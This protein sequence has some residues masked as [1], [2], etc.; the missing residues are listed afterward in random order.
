MGNRIERHRSEFR[1]TLIL[2]GA[3]LVGT[4][5]WA[6]AA[7]HNWYFTFPGAGHHWVSV[8]GPYNEHL[9]RD[10]G[11]LL[12]GIGLLLLASAVVLSRPLV[13]AALG[14]TLVWAVP[15]FIFHM[16]KLEDMPTGDNIVNMVS[17][18]LTVIV[19]IGLLALTLKPDTQIEKTKP[20]APAEQPAGAQ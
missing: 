11:S 10:F 8:L 17:L 9:T 2:L 5:G 14:T 12:L 1:V 19:P 16:T 20:T 15:H 6:L 3:P 7:P 13:Q 4:G 18:G